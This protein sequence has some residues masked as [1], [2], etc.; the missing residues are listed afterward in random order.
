MDLKSLDFDCGSAGWEILPLNSAVQ[1]A[2]KAS[3]KHSPA[4]TSVDNQACSYHTIADLHADCA[5]AL[6]PLV[7]GPGRGERHLAL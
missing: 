5:Q 2:W 4:E 7:L 1:R 3:R 6:R